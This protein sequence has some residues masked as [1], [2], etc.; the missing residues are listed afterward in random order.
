MIA[1]YAFF[2]GKLV[3][4]RTVAEK[5]E[6]NT[7]GHVKEAI[8]ELLEEANEEVRRACDWIDHGHGHT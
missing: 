6:E 8:A 5:L 3:G 1:N 7:Y 2:A 4:I